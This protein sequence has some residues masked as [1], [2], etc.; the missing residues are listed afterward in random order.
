MSACCKRQGCNINFVSHTQVDAYIADPETSTTNR[1][2]A[3]AYKDGVAN[4]SF[5]QP[6]TFPHFLP[7]RKDMVLYR[8]Q[9][10]GKQEVDGGKEAKGS[11]A[12]EGD[13]KK[14]TKLTEPHKL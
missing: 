5:I 8:I 12:A 7:N 6:T 13:T 9:Q 10:W 2:I 1:L 4:G 11:A 14:A 3:Q